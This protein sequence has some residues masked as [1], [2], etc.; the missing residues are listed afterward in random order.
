MSVYGPEEDSYFLKNFI[1][2]KDLEGQKFLDMGTGT[3][4]I[5]LEAAKNGAEV[6]AADI[7][8]EAI[9]KA[10]QNAVEE[11]FDDIEFVE[12]DLFEKI[13]QKFDLIVFN[14]PYLSGSR[15]SDEDALVGGEKG[16]EIIERFLKAVSEDLNEGG[17][18]FFIG[19]S[20][21]EIEGLKNEYEIE[22]VNSKNLWFERLYLFRFQA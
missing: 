8:H 15:S 3:G 16:T 9:T 13:D 19:S 6:T 7:N 14:P 21:S 22:L 20:N 17:E 2:Q 12:T 18:A 4:I 5:A 1:Q 10:K 11:G